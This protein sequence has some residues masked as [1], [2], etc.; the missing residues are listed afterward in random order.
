MNFIVKSIRQELDRDGVIGEIVQGWM[1]YYGIE[2]E[3]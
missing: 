3:N 1:D 2:L